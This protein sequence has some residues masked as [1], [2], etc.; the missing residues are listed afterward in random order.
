MLKSMLKVKN[1]KEKDKA[2]KSWAL[3][4]YKYCVK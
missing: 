3:K 1:Q 4:S 2:D